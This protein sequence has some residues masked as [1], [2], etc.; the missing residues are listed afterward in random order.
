MKYRVFENP[1]EFNDYAL[2]FLLQHEAENNLILGIALGITRPDSR[3]KEFYL[4]SVE[5]DDGE[6]V[7]IV[8]QTLPFN[9]ILSHMDTPN[10]QSIARFIAE[11]MQTE[12][13]SLPGVLGNIAFAEEFAK[14]WQDIVGQDY[15]MHMLQRIYALVE[16]SFPEGIAGQ[17]RNIEEADR[18]IL[19]A[20]FRNFMTE[21]LDEE[22]PAEE[23]Q[24]QVQRRF[25]GGDQIGLVIWEVDGEPVSMAGFSGPT[26]NGIR[27]NAVYTPPAHRRKGYAT[28]CVAELSQMLLDKG[29]TLCFLYTDLSNSTSNSIY[30]K[31]GYIPVCDSAHITFDEV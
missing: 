17:M 11:K 27:V 9:L 7:A 23:I 29:H 30:Q 21:A 8:F 3:Y 14:V 16:V 26:P 6:I 5:E 1:S 4:A 25:D 24:K 15:H 13:E 18:P 2:P 28:A 12:V 22:P 19:E 20:W 10:T 31:I